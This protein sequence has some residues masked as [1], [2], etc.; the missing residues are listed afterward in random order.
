VYWDSGIFC[1]DGSKE[2]SEEIAHGFRLVRIF[3]KLARAVSGVCP[4]G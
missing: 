1:Y 4:K 3:R 2:I